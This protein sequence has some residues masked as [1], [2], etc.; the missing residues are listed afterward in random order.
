[1]WSW[2]MSRCR[3][4]VVPSWWHLPQVKG[5]LSGETGEAGSFTAR[6]SCMPW[7]DAQVGASGSPAP[8]RLA[9]ERGRVLLR[10]GV[11]AGSAVDLRERRL[12]RQLLALEVGVAADALQAAVDRSA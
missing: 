12:V 3:I 4:T 6:M 2:W 9:V 1:M 7:Q 5:T 10:L 8:H 11:V